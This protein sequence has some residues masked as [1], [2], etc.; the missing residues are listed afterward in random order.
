MNPCLLTSDSLD[1][2]FA[3][4][5][6]AAD[7]WFLGAIKIRSTTSFGE[8]KSAITSRKILRRINHPYSMKDIFVG[9]IHGHFSQSLPASLLG[10][11]VNDC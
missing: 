3:G 2:R 4:S 5:Y 8:V 1:P 11:S 10:V 6:P 9:N 7:D